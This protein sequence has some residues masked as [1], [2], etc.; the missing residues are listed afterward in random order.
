MHFAQ[1]TTSRGG[2]PD[3]GWIVTCGFGQPGTFG[4]PTPE[5]TSTCSRATTPDHALGSRVHPTVI[6]R[7]KRDFVW[8]MARTPQIPEADYQRLVAELAAQG[9]DTAKLRRVPQQW[10]TAP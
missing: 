4:A 3:T 5:G 10:P 2:Q 7:N 8:I 1:R 9:Y 6:G